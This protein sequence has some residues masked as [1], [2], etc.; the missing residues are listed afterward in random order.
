MSSSAG[1]GT[2]KESAT[3]VDDLAKWFAIMVDLLQPLQPLIETVRKLAE[4]VADQDQ[5]QCA[6][7]LALL[8]LKHGDS[9]PPPLP[10][11]TTAA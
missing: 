11:P 6:M 3:T 8:R 7:N 2:G 4:Q 9:A 10:L 1:A 5:Q